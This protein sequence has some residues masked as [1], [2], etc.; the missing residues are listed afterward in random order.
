AAALGLLFGA[1]LPFWRG[2]D[3]HLCQPVRRARHSASTRVAS[4]SQTPDATSLETAALGQRPVSRFK[5]GKTSQV[6]SLID[7][8]VG[9]FDARTLKRIGHGRGGHAA[10]MPARPF[11]CLLPWSLLRVGR[12]ATAGSPYTSCKAMGSRARSAVPGERE[13]RSP[14]QLD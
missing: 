3:T 13:H 6:P 10:T 11:C 12:S 4:G 5:L 7:A 2:A 8:P 14:S 9:S 1:G